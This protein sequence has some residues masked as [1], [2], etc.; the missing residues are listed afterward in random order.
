MAEFTK[1]QLINLARENV[2]VLKQAAMQHKVQPVIAMDLRLAEIALAALTAGMEQEPVAYIAKY[3]SGTIHG[4][5]DRDD[6]VKIEWLKRGMSVTPLYA[7]PQLPQP[8]VPDENGLLRCP[9]CGS[10]ARVVD[11]RLGFY[12]QC[13]SDNCDGI[14]IGPRAPEL[15][16]EQEEKSIDWEALAQAAKDKWN[17]RA[18]MLNRQCV[19]H[20]DGVLPITIQPA[21][22]L[23]LFPK[24]DESPTTIKPVAD[25][26]SIVAPGGRSATYSTDAVEASDCRVM[27]W[28]A[29]EYVTLERYQAAM[30]QGAE[31]DF[32]EIANSSTKHF[33]ESAET[34]TKCWCYTCRPVTMTDMRFVVCPECGN[35]RC[36]HA[37]DHRNTCTGS[38][39]P[40]Q[41]GSAYPAAPQQECKHEFV[42][43]W[44]SYGR[45]S[46]YQCR[47]CGKLQEVK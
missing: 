7:A 5:C 14:A 9:F 10:A 2:R 17:R 31:P 19:D 26:Y 16:S 22:A 42:Y 37:N 30:L 39:E 47:F 45:Q 34:S 18:A 4:V 25:L 38:N 44:H 28:A 32:R 12:V 15:Q 35:K 21:S 3:E 36:P 33:R 6:T 8:A 13:C 43:G 40:G 27:G 11:N 46:G 29:Q 1:E 20:V 41:E 23:G 24:N